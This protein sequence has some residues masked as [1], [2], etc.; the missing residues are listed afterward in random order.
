M[1]NKA[2][3]VQ[4][5]PCVLKAVGDTA[6]RGAGMLI[7]IPTLGKTVPVKTRLGSTS[8]IVYVAFVN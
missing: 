1:E 4:L 3:N 2:A 7:I 5:E 8:V 6:V